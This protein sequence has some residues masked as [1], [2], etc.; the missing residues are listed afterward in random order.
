MLLLTQ[1]KLTLAKIKFFL[2]LSRYDCFST[3]RCIKPIPRCA[4]L[5]AS[6]KLTT[7]VRLSSCISL[8]GPTVFGYE[9]LSPTFL[10]WR[11]EKLGSL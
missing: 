8:I 11:K 2:K 6:T 5:T 3:E 10:V 4:D 7:E 9:G 1:T